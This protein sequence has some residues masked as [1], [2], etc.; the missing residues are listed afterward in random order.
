MPK[1]KLLIIIPAFN[2]EESLGKIKKSLDNFRYDYILVNDGSKDKT[3]EIAKRLNFNVIDLANNLGIGGAVQTGFIYAKKNKYD[4]AV[5]LDGDGQHDPG[6]IDKMVD[7][8]I[9]S[10]SDIVIGSR[11]INGDDATSTTTARIWGIRLLRLLIQL[12]T[13]LKIKDPTSGF[14]LYN[15]KAIDYLGYYY[16]EDYPEPEAIV[17]LSRHGFKIS[18]IN[19]K[20]HKRMAGKSSITPIK[21]LL[22]MAKV[23]FSILINQIRNKEYDF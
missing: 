22:Y 8:M 7:K 6:E 23:A 19:V 14:R 9:K 21:S 18:E 20:M 16:P 10:R 12:V 3:K 13:R 17:A 5:Q 11:F 2:E 4:Y 1:H 15:K